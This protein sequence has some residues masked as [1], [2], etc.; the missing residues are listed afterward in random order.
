MCFG[1]FHPAKNVEVPPTSAGGAPRAKS[2]SQTI[3]IPYKRHLYQIIQ[4]AHSWVDR[5]ENRPSGKRDCGKDIS[6]ENDK[7]EDRGPESQRPKTCFDF[8]IESEG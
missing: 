2:S 4:I 7:M 8:S 5:C 1:G 6:Q 3:M